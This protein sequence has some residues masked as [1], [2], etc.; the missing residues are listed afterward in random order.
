MGNSDSSESGSETAA[1]GASRDP[2]AE[3]EEAFEVIYVGI[4][5]RCADGGSAGEAVTYAASHGGA[6]RPLMSLYGGRDGVLTRKAVRAVVRDSVAMLG[7]HGERIVREAFERQEQRL[8]P[9]DDE[10]RAVMRAAA[11]A[12][13][14]SM[15]GAL[16]RAAARVDADAEELYAALAPDSGGDVTV[17]AFFPAYARW[18]AGRAARGFRG[19]GADRAGAAAAGRS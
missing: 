11:A 10:G 1:S 8:A 13:A 2:Q 9:D 19:D 6:V 4:L 16:R 5:E 18:L 7:R 15:P 14:R 17:D 3:A 12:A